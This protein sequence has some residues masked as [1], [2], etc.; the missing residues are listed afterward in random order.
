MSM[1]LAYLLV[2][3]VPILGQTSRVSP[4]TKAPGD[5]VTLEISADSQPERAP[6]ALKWEVIF[7]AQLMEIETDAPQMGS[8]AKDSGKSLQCT[9]T[10]PYSRVCVL[11]GGQKPIG[12]GPVAIYHFQIRATAQAGITS[13]KIQGAESTTTDSKKWLLNDTEA[14]V[15]I[16]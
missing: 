10:K 1:R 12:N 13:L 8:A 4:V 9:S 7:P 14:I 5:K 3:C 11:S 15:V 6:I 2:V 16:R